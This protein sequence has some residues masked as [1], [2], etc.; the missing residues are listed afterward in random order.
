MIGNDIILCIMIFSWNWYIS[1]ALNIWFNIEMKMLLPTLT[2]VSHL[3]GINLQTYIRVRCFPYQQQKGDYRSLT[4]VRFWKT[5]PWCSLYSL[6]FQKLDKTY[7]PS[8]ASRNTPAP[9][10]YRTDGV[11][12][13]HT[14]RP[15]CI[16]V[17]REHTP[18]YCYWSHS[19]RQI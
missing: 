6:N 15:S 9:K 8:S 3:F 12:R 5:S 11:H 17:T 13:R 1:C 7:S 4:L 10:T 16:F 18:F 2:S 14:H 19:W